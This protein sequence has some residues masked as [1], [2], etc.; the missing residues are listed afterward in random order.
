MKGLGLVKEV[1]VLQNVQQFNCLAI[2]DLTEMKT[3]VNF[4]YSQLKHLSYWTIE[5]FRNEILLACQ[6]D[7][8]AEVI[9]FLNS[10]IRITSNK[11]LYKS[12]ISELSN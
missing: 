5:V 11:I 8:N 6:K 9:L 2:K 1:L 7:L 12:I 3:D 4:R 10:E